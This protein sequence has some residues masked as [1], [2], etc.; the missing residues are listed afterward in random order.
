LNLNGEVV[1][2]APTLRPDGVMPLP[3]LKELGK[4]KAKKQAEVSEHQAIL[5]KP[6]ATV[7]FL[8][9]QS[10]AHRVCVVCT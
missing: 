5:C 4:R 7:R 10:V 3:D 8:G 1:A 6:T 2:A 9:A